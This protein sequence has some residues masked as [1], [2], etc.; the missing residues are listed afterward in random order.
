[1]GKD[2]RVAVLPP[3]GAGGAAAAAAAT[4]PASIATGADRPDTAMQVQVAKKRRRIQQ[5][6]GAENEG[7]K[8][9]QTRSSSSSSSS[10]TLR[11]HSHHRRNRKSKRKSTKSKGKA[12]HSAKQHPT[13][14]GCPPPSRKLVDKI[15][16]G[17]YVPFHK[18]LLPPGHP[19]PL[20]TNKSRRKQPKRVMNS[21][22]LWLEAWNRF[23]GVLIA[24]KPEKALELAQYQTLLCMAFERYPHEACVEYDSCFRQ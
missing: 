21:L 9:T 10:T 7:H 20:E 18:L 5:G 24:H 14:A 22:S 6:L 3:R 1:M 15:R 11:S 4:C 2:R 23:T 12:R 16:K 8:A 17:E 19:Y 13:V